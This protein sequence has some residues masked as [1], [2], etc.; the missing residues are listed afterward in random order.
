MGEPIKDKGLTSVFTATFSFLSISFDKVGG[1]CNQI[2][3]EH[4]RRAFC[5]GGNER[6]STEWVS[7]GLLLMLLSQLRTD[8]SPKDLLPGLEVRLLNHQAIGVAWYLNVD[9]ILAFI[10]LTPSK[11]ARERKKSG[12]RRNTCVSHLS[13]FIDYKFTS[14]VCRDDMGLGNPNFFSLITLV[15]AK[16]F[17]FHRQN[18][19]NDSDHGNEFARP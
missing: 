15:S 8:H 12:S 2:Y 9:C 7:M 16:C 17:D 1:F 6:A 19:A 11:D 4:E 10:F 14:V 13:L 18:C 5:E 3:R